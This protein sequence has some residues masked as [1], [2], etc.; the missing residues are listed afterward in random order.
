MGADKAMKFAVGSIGKVL[1]IMAWDVEMLKS[2]GE[3]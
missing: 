1:F 2:I 3:V